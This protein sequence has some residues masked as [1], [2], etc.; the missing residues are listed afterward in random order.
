GNRTRVTVRKNKVAPPFKVAEFDIMY[1]EG[2]SKAGDLLDLAV[3]HDVVEKRGAYYRF[4]DE[5]IGQGRESA[6][7]FLN[8][9]PQ[10]A[11]QIDRI[12]R[13]RAG[14]PAPAEV[15]GQTAEGA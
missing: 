2:I 14:L 10:I 5:L 1:N 7:T 4:N 15:E 9:N 8:E 11:N 13:E 3:E 12:I 6:K